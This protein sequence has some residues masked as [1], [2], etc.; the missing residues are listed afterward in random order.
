MDPQTALPKLLAIAWLLPLASFALILLFGPR[1]GKAGKGGGY[2]ATAAIGT[3]CLL[4]LIALFGVWLPTHGPLPPAG[5]HEEHG[6]DH[7]G[8]SCRGA[9]RHEADS[10][11]VDGRRLTAYST[12][13]TITHAADGKGKPAE[14]AAAESTGED[15]A[16]NRTW[17]P[18]LKRTQ[19]PKPMSTRFP[20]RT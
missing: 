10:H 2:L 18:V 20:Q 4:S 11:G 14:Q 7:R 19:N 15:Q 13:T 17:L 9:I 1:M 5:H 12:T 16:D 6:A 3:S 8:R